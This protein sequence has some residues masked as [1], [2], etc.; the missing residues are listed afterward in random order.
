[1][2]KVLLGLL[3]AAA[4]LAVLVDCVGDSASTNTA[5]SDG[6]S[7]TTEDGSTAQASDGGS[8][9]S[10]DGAVT[11]LD[12]GGTTTDGGTDGGPACNLAKPF[13]A[14][15]LLNSVST[16]DTDEMARISPNGLELFVAHYAA[17]APRVIA[18]YTRVDL[19]SPWTFA[20]DDTTLSSTTPDAGRTT[21]TALTLDPTGTTAYFQY[22]PSPTNGSDSRIYVTSRPAAGSNQWG[23]QSEVPGIHATATDEAPML[24]ASGN[25]LYFFTSRLGGYH[26]Y[27]AN[28]SGNGFLAPTAVFA[29]SP[30]NDRYPVLSPDELTMY[31]GSYGVV[32]G[33]ANPFMGVYVT[34]RSKSSDGFGPP[35]YVPEL[36][37]PGSF[38][39]PTWLSPDGCQILLTSNRGANF[40]IWLAVKPK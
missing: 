21:A 32:D 11:G 31:I 9:T 3:G 40:N 26:I 20:D 35:V 12:G 15:A 39:A 5:N 29:A 22:Y 10:G 27:S 1:M 14:P 16:G 4:G 33:G 28:K 7:T 19:N 18:R 8:Q 30:D 17:G 23:A 36:N 13:N 38:T 24:S 37:L 2:R 6:G 25:R 34:S